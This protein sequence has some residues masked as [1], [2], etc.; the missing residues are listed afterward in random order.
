[1]DSR[2]RAEKVILLSNA[3]Q[4]VKMNEIDKAINSELKKVRQALDEHL[5]SINDN[6]QEIQSL[7]DYLQEIEVKV[8]KL[9]QRL[10][11]TQLN[12]QNSP[13][14]P[15]VAPLNQMERKIFLTLYTA[16][17]PLS[18]REISERSQISPTIVHECISSL[19]SKGIPLIRTFCNDQMFFKIEPVFKEVQAKENLINLSLQSFME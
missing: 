19:T 5:N 18:Y 1:V 10:D 14:K 4:K 11:Q 9:S 6:T 13:V 7:F 12:N 2:N 17:M 8:E 16:E 15:C 3:Y